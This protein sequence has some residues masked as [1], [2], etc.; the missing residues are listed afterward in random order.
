MLE[1]LKKFSITKNFGTL[2]QY[3]KTGKFS[4]AILL[5]SNDGYSSF[6]LAKLLALSIFQ[7]GEL[8]FDLPDAIQIQLQTHSDVK[9]LPEKETFLVSDAEILNNESYLKP[10]SQD[11]KIFI[12]K[13]IDK[14]TIQAQ[15]KLLKIIEEPPK[16]KYYIFRWFF[17]SFQKCVKRLWCKHMHFI[18][19]INFIFT[20][21]WR[22][23]NF[24]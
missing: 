15:N 18:N 13:N 19:N 20:I 4:H 17:N 2:N 6:N 5:A 24:F 12:I 16:N 3:V 1:E 7:R 8:N 11:K 21:N 23:L 14:S 10:V 22:I 9:F